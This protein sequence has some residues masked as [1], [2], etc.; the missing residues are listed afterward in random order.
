M[1]LVSNK[2]IYITQHQD[3][4]TKLSTLLMNDF[5]RDFLSYILYIYLISLRV[6]RVRV[7][8]RRIRR[9]KI[10]RGTPSVWLHENTTWSFQ[11]I[12]RVT[13]ASDSQ[14]SR[15]YTWEIGHKVGQILHLMFYERKQFF[16]TKIC[17]YTLSSANFYSF[18]NESL[19][20]HDAL[21]RDE[22]ASNFVLFSSN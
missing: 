10:L 13:S 16:R 12:I 20:I 5:I 14:N 6:L 19:L 3:Q 18:C 22:T 9:A 11:L 2:S 17:I 1:S 4:K 8:N 7:L 21:M 15:L